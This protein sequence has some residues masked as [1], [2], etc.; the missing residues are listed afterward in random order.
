MVVDSLRR[1]QAS[2]PSASTAV[3]VLR[4]VRLL[5]LAAAAVLALIVLTPFALH[6][7]TATGSVADTASPAP[8]PSPTPRR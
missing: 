2:T 7:R 1:P 6:E 4:G 3:R 8:M 5:V